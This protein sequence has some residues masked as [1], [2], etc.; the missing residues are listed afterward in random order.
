MAAETIDLE[1]RRNGFSA[2][3]HD[4]AWRI[5][6]LAKS[7]L[8]P[9]P[10]FRWMVRHWASEDSGLADLRPPRD[11][12][13]LADYQIHPGLLDGAFQ[14]LGGVLPGAGEGIDAYV[15]MGVERLQ[16]HQRPLEPAWYVAS[17]RSLEG[18]VATGDVQLVDA[19]GRVLAR[20]EGVQLRRV[21]RDWL[22]RR[23]AGPLPHWCYELAWLPQ[24]M[25]TTAS[26]QAAAP[27]RWLIFDS[28]D[29]LG[30]ALAE[31]LEMKAHR[32]TLVPAVAD[33]DSRRAAVREFAA[34][35]GPKACG[36]VYL[37]GL[38]VDA[39]QMEPDFE[40]ARRHG[41]GG[42]LDIVHV[43]A[44]AAGPEPPR[45]WLVTPRRPTGGRRATARAR[46][47]ARLGTGT[48]HR[49]RASRPRLHAH[50]PRSRT[51]RG[52]GRPAH[53]RALLGGS[54]RT[55]L[56]IAAASAASPGCGTRGMPTTAPW[57]PRTANPTGWKSF[58]AANWTTWR[59]ARRR[60]GARNRGKSKSA[61]APADSTSATYSTCST[62][63]RAIRARWAANAPA[64]LPP[65]GRASSTFKPGDQVV[66]L[67]PASFAS[68]ALTS[69]EFVAPKPAHLSFDE[70][71]TI[72][73]C[74]VTAHLA[75][76]RLGQLRPGQRILIHAG[77]GGVGLAAIQIARQIGAEC[78]ATA[79][80]PRKREYL[81][82]L[83]I[84]HV[85][86]SR[87]LDFAQQIMHATAGE[88]VDVVL[89]SLTGEAIPAG[90]SV[91]RPGGRFLELGKTDL[92]DQQRVDQFKPGVAFFAIAL[93]RMMADQPQ[94]VGE[95]LREVLA[96]F[97]ERK[98]R[99]LPLRT[100]RIRRAVDALRHM[101]RSRTHRQGGDPSRGA[102]RCGRSRVRAP[103]G[104][105]LSG[106]RRPG[107]A[108]A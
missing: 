95:L 21:P 14:L 59:C 94:Q 1:A 83:G 40:A 88:G 11:D 79:G 54:A 33:A 10:T 13:H 72:P 80:S 66:A 53:G 93:D 31:R 105:H 4:E 46:A 15:P 99:A 3:P 45:L 47:I 108:W 64:R 68:Y 20:L 36:V 78:F 92:W 44:D 82:S 103:R 51:P 50:R 7:G 104:G 22:A 12:D 63:I 25:D 70:A 85:M 43:L 6:A 57:L 39:R 91:L 75:L 30:A 81:E 100:F 37:S 24:P 74:F 77:A 65:S 84:Q 34:T 48:R 28:Q 8:Q 58:L 17:L 89:N 18:N 27:G 29:G 96:E 32:C 60:G 76:R 97:A 55:R 107:R 98:L 90:L 2:E 101:A 9:G 106:H 67:A 42:I 61:S 5:E 19:G 16:L 73:I 87:S 26:Q 52:S 102:R 69:P 38:D 23:L 62:C 41:W 49:L 71:A 86:D 35:A 56:P